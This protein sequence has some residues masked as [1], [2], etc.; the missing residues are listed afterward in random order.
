MKGGTVQQLEKII[1][2]LNNVEDIN[3]DFIDNITTAKDELDKGAITDE[4]YQKIRTSWNNAIVNFN[5]KLDK[6]QDV[7]I[8]AK[9]RNILKNV[10]DTMVE[11]IDNGV[12]DNLDKM[13]NET[14]GVAQPTTE[15]TLQALKQQ[16]M[17]I[18]KKLGCK[19]EN[20]TE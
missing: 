16:L 4:E 20:L 11:K 9:L 13:S 15:K 12:V 7:S 6:L 17:E 1:V 19:E 18:K 2:T 8:K 5:V 10:Q 14:Q 3:Q